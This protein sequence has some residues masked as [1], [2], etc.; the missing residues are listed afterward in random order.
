VVACVCG[1]PEIDYLAQRWQLSLSRNLFIVGY[2]SV[3]MRVL[4][5]FMRD[6]GWF[7]KHFD[8]VDKNT[9]I[10]LT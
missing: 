8:Y 9:H 7:A 6:D 5:I 2:G 3:A 10:I 1:W 4:L